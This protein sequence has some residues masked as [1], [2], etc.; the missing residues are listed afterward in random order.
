MQGTEAGTEGDIARGWWQRSWASHDAVIELLSY[1]H[2]L[3]AL[4]M[5]NDS[6]EGVSEVDLNAWDG[7][8]CR[9]LCGGMTGKTQLE[10]GH[11]GRCFCEQT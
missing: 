10:E 1:E 5:G 8:H 11:L 2:E 6:L 4:Q 3:S 7:E 9:N